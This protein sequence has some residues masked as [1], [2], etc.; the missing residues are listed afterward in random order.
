[1]EPIHDAQPDKEGQIQEYF[2]E[3]FNEYKFDIY[4]GDVQ[5]FTQDLWQYWEGS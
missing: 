1:L 4:W 5:S 2:Q 3:Y